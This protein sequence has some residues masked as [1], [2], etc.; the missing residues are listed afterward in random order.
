MTCRK[1]SL[2]VTPSVS[3]KLRIQVQLN[4]V[5]TREHSL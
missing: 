4:Y 1:K 5:V 3:P 2:D